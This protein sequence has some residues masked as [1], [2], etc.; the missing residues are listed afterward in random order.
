MILS[1]A[2]LGLCAYIAASC[3]LAFYFPQSV[4]AFLLVEA[5]LLLLYYAPVA[6]Q[7][8]IFLGALVLLVLL[9]FLGSVNGYY[10]EVAIQIGIYVALALGLNIVVGFVGLLNLGFVAFY[11]IGA[12]LWAVFGSPQANA[13]IAGGFFP[14]SA[15]W[16]FVFLL[17]SIVVGAL[18]GALLGLPVLRVRG[19]YLAVVTLGFAEVVRALVNN[20]DKPINLTNGPRGISPISK[21]PLFFRPVLDFFGLQ[22]S[23][24]KLYPLYFYFLVLL[25]VLVIIVVTHRL[26][27]SRVGRAWKAIREDEVAASAMGVPVVRMKLLG[28][29]VG[30]SFACAVG[31]LFAAKQV[32]INPESFTFMESI[33]VLAMVILGGMGSIPGAVLG[34]TGVTILNLQLLKGLSLWLNGL[35]QSGAELVIPFVGS[36]PLSQLPAQ[37]EPAKYERMV[38]GL[39]LILMMVFRPQGILPPRQG[40]RQ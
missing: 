34:A 30:A 2:P 32:F 24:A 38:F 26:E 21:P 4:L 12:Y 22:I 28:F 37:F 5:S 11:A 35:R 8:K 10:L 13:F 25:M 7:V 18:T 19:D 39:I 27:Y 3:L 17:L 33:G 23:D 15:N 31:V 36:Y 40:S 9:P 14:L 16:F 29:A 6:A 20:L 1:L